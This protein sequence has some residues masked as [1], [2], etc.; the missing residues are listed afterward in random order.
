M[1]MMFAARILWVLTVVTPDALAL[2]PTRTAAQEQTVPA[3]RAP[4]YEQHQE[5]INAWTIGLAAGRIEGAPLR[6]AAEM[7]RVVDDGANQHVLPIVTRG[8]TENL[9]W[10]LYL[11]G[12]DLAIINSDALDEYRIGLVLESR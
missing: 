11:R 1:T 4:T 5:K 10:L 3:R 7:A 8:P 6:L 2:Q 12:V 9:N